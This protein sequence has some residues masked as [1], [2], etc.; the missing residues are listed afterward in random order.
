MRVVFL[1]FVFVNV[2]FGEENNISIET[3]ETNQ[4]T[5]TSK[6]AIGAIGSTKIFD[7]D[8]L[9]TYIGTSAI[10]K[11]TSGVIIHSYANGDKVIVAN[12]S[13]VSATDGKSKLQLQKFEILKNNSV[14]TTKKVAA[15]GDIFVP[16]HLY[17]NAI[18]I[19]PNMQTH[20]LIKESFFGVHFLTS[21]LFASILKI[22]D[23][24]TPTKEDMKQ[25]CKD[26][27]ISTIYV[28]IKNSLYIVDT[29]SFIV[30]AKH[31]IKKQSGDVIVPFYSLV[32]DINKGM[33]DWFSE[34][35]IGDYDSYYARL[36]GVRSAD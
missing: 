32:E 27:L 2:L 31:N 8:K 10:P 5:P 12:A 6:P 33:F 29:N 19:A 23:N 4:T 7:T 15:D 21:D 35:D 30:V 22:D 34:D 16:R 26:N 20:K 24:P 25:F 3:N 36:F 28:N 18:I 13:V 1:L 9:H 14:A 11:G 17:N